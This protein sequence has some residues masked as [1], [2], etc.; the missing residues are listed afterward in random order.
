MLHPD[1]SHLPVEIDQPEP[2]LHAREELD[3]GA[4]HFQLIPF[5]AHS[6][7]PCLVEHQ[8]H[9]SQYVA[10][11]LPLGDTVAHFPEFSRR[12]ADCLDESE[13]LHVAGGEGS[14]EVVDQCYYGF[15]FHKVLCISIKSGPSGTNR[16]YMKCSGY[17]Q[18]ADIQ[19]G[20]PDP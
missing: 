14:V 9:V 19:K 5:Q 2:L 11:I 1:P 20:P 7:G 18:V 6:L 3:S 10:G 12:L 13:F 16:K 8:L 17:F 15:A 4:E